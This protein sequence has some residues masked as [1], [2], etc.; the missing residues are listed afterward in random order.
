MCGL[1]L[2][3]RDR[4]QIANVNHRAL[5]VGG[6]HQIQRVG[7]CVQHVHALVHA[8]ARQHAHDPA[9]LAVLAAGLVAAL[10]AADTVEEERARKEGTKEREIHKYINSG[11]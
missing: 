6:D 9:P 7:E 5:V 8:L 1:N 4:V 2:H 3:A 10:V 11:K